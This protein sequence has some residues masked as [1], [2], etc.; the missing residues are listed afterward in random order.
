MG[1][2]PELVFM[3][4]AF[5]EFEGTQEELDAFIAHIKEIFESKSIEELDEISVEFDPEF[6]S[7]FDFEFTPDTR[8]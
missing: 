8:V 2:K 3:P 6:E 1:E 4:G 7:D 5:D